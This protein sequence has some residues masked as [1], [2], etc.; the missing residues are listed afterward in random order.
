M[1]E[2]F[3]YKFFY[4]FYFFCFFFV[5]FY[6]F[7]SLFFFKIFFSNFFCFLVQLFREKLLFIV[8]NSLS[9]FFFF[10]CFVFGPQTLKHGY[11][12][13]TVSMEKCFFNDVWI[14]NAHCNKPYVYTKVLLF[15]VHLLLDT[16]FNAVDSTLEQFIAGNLDCTH[17]YSKAWVCF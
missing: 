12:C 16:F 3:C 13:F 11:C 14:Q 1:K 10:F 2:L 4:C 9:F 17:K 6:F 8:F 5:F 7:F 15:P